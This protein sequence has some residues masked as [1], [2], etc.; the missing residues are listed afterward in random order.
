MRTRV[1]IIGAGPAGLLLS[2]LLHRRG[3]ES[4]VLENRS[5]DYCEQRQR[6]GVVEHGVAEV[7]RESGVGSRMD[8]DGLVH[9]GI[10]LRFDGRAHRIDFPGL[11]GRDVMIYAQTEVVKD[12]IARRLADGGQILFGAKATS[13]EDVETDSPRIR[14]ERD[15]EADVLECDVVAACDGFHGIGRRS[16]PSGVART[17]DK[18][19]PFSWLG[20]LADVAP[21]CEELIYAHSER[22]FALHSMRSPEVSRLY[23]QVPNG[24]D[25]ADWSD[26]RIWDELSARFALRDGDW[27]LERGPITD[28]SIT[29]MRSFVTEP[30]RH[31]RLFLAGD[32]AHIVPPTG[33]K[34]LNLA[35]HDVTLLA[36]AVAAWDEKGDTALLDS[37]SDDA[38]RRVWRAE[39]F[40]YWM[41]TLLH[42][43][44]EG[45]EFDHRLQ[46][47]H[48][49]RIAA[50]TA[51]ATEL[52]ENYTGIPLV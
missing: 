42:R 2:H 51:A 30:M 45:G 39:H 35:M 43:D 37:Y 3:V 41:T 48:L 8:T 18:V 34:G 44:P 31:G 27:T 23:L 46:V 32:A 36:E 40:S 49:N 50:S 5:R 10:E 20:I 38:L 47:S 25:P 9:H 11:T 19:Y 26:E 12:L 15:G 21:S 52:A 4:V 17:F 14:F 22:G 29:P 28:K 16:L 6:A 33:A 24:T 13:V 7:L 1:G